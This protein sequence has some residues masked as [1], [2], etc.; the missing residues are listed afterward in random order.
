MLHYAGIMSLKLLQWCSRLAHGTYKEF[1]GDKAF[2]CYQKFP[3]LP[4]SEVVIMSLSCSSALLLERVGI[5]EDSP[6]MSSFLPTS[7]R[8]L[9]KAKRY[10]LTELKPICSHLMSTFGTYY[11]TE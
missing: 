1:E 2:T 5:T 9:I 6:F 4:S 7:C 8:N 3:I 10:S 11:H